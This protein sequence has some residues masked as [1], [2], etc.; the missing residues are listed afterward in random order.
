MKYENFDPVVAHFQ[1]QTNLNIKVQLQI[2]LLKIT[3][4]KKTKNTKRIKIT[5]KN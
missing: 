5:E 1:T 4:K 2:P 3:L